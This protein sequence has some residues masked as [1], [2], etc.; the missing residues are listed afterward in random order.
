[1]AASPQ[2]KAGRADARR[3]LYREYRQSV[4]D[5]LADARVRS[6]RR[7]VQHGHVSCYQHCRRVAFLS[8]RVCRQ[9]GMD[10]RA[11]ARGGMLHDMFLYDWHQKSPYPQL[12]AFHHPAVALQNARCAFPLTD[13]EQDIIRKHMWPLTPAFPRYR[14]S[15]VVSL[16]DKYAALWETAALHRRRKRR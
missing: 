10:S 15:F 5:L 13:R 16:M 6:M 7:F 11:A 8:Y 3:K 14:E 12:H 2:K 9:L 4:R 1:M